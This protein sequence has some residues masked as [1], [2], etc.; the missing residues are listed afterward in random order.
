MNSPKIKS[1]VTKYFRD[2]TATGPGGGG[3][4]VLKLSLA[5]ESTSCYSTGIQSPIQ[6]SVEGESII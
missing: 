2:G 1:G 5:G 3:S 4:T 6:L